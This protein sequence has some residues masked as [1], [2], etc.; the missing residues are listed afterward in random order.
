MCGCL[1]VYVCGHMG[2]GEVGGDGGG[3]RNTHA[4]FHAG[5]F[6]NLTHHFIYTEPTVWKRRADQ[7]YRAEL[8]RKKLAN[9]MKQI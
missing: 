1:F 3:K 9:I 6:V 8:L 7:L 5:S 4:Q 2:A